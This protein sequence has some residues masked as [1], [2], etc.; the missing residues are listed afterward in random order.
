LSSKLKKKKKKDKKEKK[1]KSSIPETEK[2]VENQQETK[3]QNILSM[4]DRLDNISQAKTRVTEEKLRRGIIESQIS[5]KDEEFKKEEIAISEIKKEIEELR[6]IKQDYYENGEIPEAIEIAKKIIK[7]ANAGQMK[8]IVNDEKMFIEQVQGE[9]S[10]KKPIDEQIEELRKKRHMYYTQEKFGEAIQIAE[11]I[12][13]LAKEADLTQII[14]TE[15]NF[16]TL[17]HE[18]INGKTSKLE[19][20]GPLKDLR[21]IEQIDT[22]KEKSK[23]TE[24][25]QSKMTEIVEID[26]FEEE[27]RK[28]EEAKEDYKLEQQKFKE[29]KDAFKWEKQM[30]EELKKF[31]RDKDLDALKEEPS[32][33]IVQIESEEKRKFEEEREKFEKEKEMLRQDVLKF[34]EVKEL[35]QEKKKKLKERKKKFKKEKLEFK[36]EKMRFEKNKLNFQEEKEA[37]KWEKQMFEEVKKF[38]TDKD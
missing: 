34:E 9:I 16:I 33:E 19:G 10:P 22:L 26:K 25:I 7:I 6:G 35:F 23:E 13:D 18:K 20:I 11:I 15:E 5:E 2:S 4:L 12:I 3:K 32:P 37:F 38:E 24:V 8:L 36:E 29:E 31:E 1:E 21:L 30:L 17:M 14:R 28:L 27:K